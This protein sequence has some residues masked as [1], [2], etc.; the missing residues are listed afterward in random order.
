MLKKTDHFILERNHTMRRKDREL[1]DIAMI[2][3]I[4]SGCH[5]CRLGFQDKEK[6]YIVPLNF[7]YTLENGKWTFYFHG[8]R[9]GRKMDVISKNPYAGF[10][11]DT[12]YSLKEGKNACSYSARFQSV[13][14]GGKISLIDD[15]AEKKAALQAIM[16]HNT[17]RTDWDFS[18]AM[19]QAAGVFKLEADELSCKEHL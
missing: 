11:L 5:C 8:A 3:K 2:E 7:G 19:L 18:D 10:E 14:G 9:E 15:P 6:V 17:D 16:Y 13:I 12:N 4:V 1:T